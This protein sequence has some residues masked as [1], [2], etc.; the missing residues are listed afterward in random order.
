M[1]EVDLDALAIER[2]RQLGKPVRGSEHGL[3]SCVETN[4][5]GCSTDVALHPQ[6]DGP[7]AAH[8]LSGSANPA[9]VL[10]LERKE[11]V[12]GQEIELGALV[13]VRMVESAKQQKVVGRVALLGRDLRVA[14]R[15][16]VARGDVVSHLTEQYGSTCQL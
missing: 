2:Q 3:G 13:G 14:A 4:V 8:A 9:L 15:P 11:L 1:A 5:D 6:Q 16:G 7:L 12:H 10:G